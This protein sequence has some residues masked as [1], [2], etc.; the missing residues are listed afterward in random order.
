MA[1]SHLVLD[2]HDGLVDAGDEWIAGRGSCGWKV[3][4]AAEPQTVRPGLVWRFVLRNSI[5][6]VRGGRRPLWCVARV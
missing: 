4:A 1:H 2:L 6:E 5:G 3:P